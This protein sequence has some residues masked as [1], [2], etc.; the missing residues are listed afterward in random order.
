MHIIFYLGNLKGRDHVAQFD[1][2]GMI[3]INPILKTWGMKS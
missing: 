3:T 2:D 1:V